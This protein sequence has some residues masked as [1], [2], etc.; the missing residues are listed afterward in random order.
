MTNFAGTAVRSVI[1]YVFTFAL[2]RKLSSSDLGS[3]FLI[4]TVVN[5]LSL[6][7]VLGLGMG[8]VRYVSLYA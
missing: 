5:I 6:F 3:Y 8:V 1:L 2:A 7:A 4:A